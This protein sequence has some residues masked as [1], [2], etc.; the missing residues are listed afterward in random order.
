VLRP[1]GPFI[2]TMEATHSITISLVLP[3]VGQLLK[4]TNPSSNVMLLDYSDDPTNVTQIK[5]KVSTN[6]PLPSMTRC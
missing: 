4:A 2:S 5:M 1:M 6:N 3:M